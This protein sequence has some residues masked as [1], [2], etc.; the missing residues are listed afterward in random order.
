[1]KS[2]LRRFCPLVLGVL[3]GF[4]RLRFRGS[5]RQLC[6]PQGVMGYFSQASVLLKDYEKAYAKDTTVTL[7]QAIEKPAKEAGLYQYLNN[8]KVSK[9]ETALAL[10]ARHGRTQGLVAVLSC[11]E[12]SWNLRVRKNRDTKLLEPRLEE[13]KCQHYYHYYLD[14]V[15][16]LRY[17]RLQSWFPFT[18]HVGLNGRDWLGQQL[19]K[20]GIPFRKEDNCFCWIEDFDGAQE[21]LDEQLRTEWAPLLNGW[22]RARF[23]EHDRLLKRALPYYWSVQEAEYAT[24]IAFRSAADLARLYPA[25]VQHA[26]ATLHGRDL[27]QFLNYRVRPDG[28]PLALGEVK[29]TIQELVQGTCVRHRV[30]QNLLKMYDKRHTVLRVAS[31][32]LDLEHFK[33]F[34]AK[35]GDEHGP[36][37]YRRLRKGVADLHRRAEVS[38]KINDRY[39]TS[40]ASVEEKQTLAELTK[41]LGQRRPWQGRTVRALNPLSTEDASL[42][43]AVSRGAFMIDGFCNRQVHAILYPTS[44]Q[45]DAAEQK[46][47]SGK[48]TRFFRIL[49]GHGLIAK[50]QKTHR[51][52]VTAKGR[53]ILSA[54]VAARQ[55][56]TKHL[57]QAA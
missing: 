54:L 26:Y 28:R 44:A 22:M 11:V 5:K 1:M 47:L 50:V 9:E 52:Q 49:R 7:C 27:L 23:P 46:R 42:L 29:T 45:A 40:L 21:L 38:Q 2:F 25:W 31:L 8:C 19:T 32:L 6:Y 18:M 15:Y 39:V 41:D 55:A 43:E 24:D 4:D 36:L 33:V 57:L 30:L 12:P 37:S 14:P 10:A 51:Y 13:G 53:T 20:A 56:N 35:E 3:L 34:R 48:V 17:T 16:G